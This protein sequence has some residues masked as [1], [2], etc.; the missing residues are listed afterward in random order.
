MPDPAPPTG[1]LNRTVIGAGLTS[2]LADVAYEMATAV[3]PGFFT[4][5]AIPG[6]FLGL[7]EGT[8]DALANFVKLGVGYYSDRIGRRKALVVAGYGLTGVSLSLF[9]FA[10]SWP[11]ILLGKSLAWIGKGLRGPLRDAIL[12]DSVPPAMVGRAFGFHRAGDTVGAVI[13]PLLGALLV[14]RTAG[15]G[16]RHPRGPAPDRIPPDTDPRHRLRARILVPGPRAAVHARS[17][18]SGSASP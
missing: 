3:M 1:W 9:A 6:Y 14:A 2:L 10:V 18:Q 4:V 11:L 17:R 15:H 8:G 5:L 7:T 13:G 16:L 12:A